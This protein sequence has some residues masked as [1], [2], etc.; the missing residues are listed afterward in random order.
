VTSLAKNDTTE[1]TASKVKQKNQFRSLGSSKKS[2]KR[3]ISLK[4]VDL[5]VKEDNFRKYIS[6][7]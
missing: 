1:G 5:E 2:T 4:S 6:K 3:R 7:I